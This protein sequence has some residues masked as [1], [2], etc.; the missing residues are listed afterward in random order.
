MLCHTND[1][2]KIVY[3][4]DPLFNLLF[5]CGTSTHIYDIWVTTGQNDWSEFV[6]IILHSHFTGHKRYYPNSFNNFQ[7]SSAFNDLLIYM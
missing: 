2:K 7:S 5:L 1:D 3:Q 6:K 4:Y